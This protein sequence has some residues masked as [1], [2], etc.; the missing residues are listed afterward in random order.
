MRGLEFFKSLV[1]FDRENFEAVFTTKR[2]GR[3]ADGPARPPSISSI[4]QRGN[5]VN[6]ASTAAL[7]GAPNGTAYYASKFRSPWHDGV[8]ASG[9]PEIQ[10]PGI[11]GESERGPYETSTRS[12]GCRRRRNATKLRGEDIA[13]HREGDA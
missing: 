8:L 13:P 9:T 6:I 12:P 10:Y 2:H 4:G 1:D 3:H 11:S 5:I 7:R